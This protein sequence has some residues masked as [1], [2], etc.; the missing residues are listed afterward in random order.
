MLS[1]LI[2]LEIILAS[3][4]NI[5]CSSSEGVRLWEHGDGNKN[6]QKPDGESW[7]HL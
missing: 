4:T 2:Y 5:P 7:T 1:G 6:E 3:F